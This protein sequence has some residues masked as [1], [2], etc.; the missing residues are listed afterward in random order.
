M[1]IGLRLLARFASPVQNPELLLK[2]T[3]GWFNEKCSDLLPTTRNGFIESS[4][5]LFCLLHPAA[6]E[7]ELSLIDP[8]HLVA[9]A[10]T[11]AVGPGYHI[12]LCELL[13]QW[14]HDFH[15]SWQQ[16]EQESEDYSDEAEYFFTGDEQQVFD[17]M[18]RWLQAVAGTFFE[19]R[20]DA[21]EPVALCMPMDVQF[22]SEQ[23]AITPL[24]PRDR[25]WLNQT[26]QD[27]SQGRDFFAWWKPGLNAEYFLGRAL[28]NMWTNVRWRKP[29][30]DRERKLLKEVD[31]SL[32]IACRLNTS[33][34]YPWAEWKEIL[35]NLEAC[36]EDMESFPSRAQ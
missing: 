32:R 29:V 19:G 17:N 6:E 7:V 18:T 36:A 24:G 14:A 30:N 35:E 26:S 31:N 22:E 1:S 21:N 8:E 34:C 28:A 27:G 5:T 4:P 13:K 9:S 23:P 16:P 33:L 12:Y 2:E 3:A 25:E 11:S 15:A 10:N 20:L